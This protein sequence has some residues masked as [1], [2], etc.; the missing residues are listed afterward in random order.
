MLNG[1][2]MQFN[3][4]E[5]VVKNPE[6]ESIATAARKDNLY[7][8]NFTKVH[9]A[10]T[11]NLVRSPMGDDVLQFWH[12]HLDHLNAKGVHTLQ[13]MMSGMNLAPHHCCFAKRTSKVNNKGLRLGIP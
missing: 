2:Q 9:G 13:N 1:F 5:R 8:M 12:W 11:T 4:N 10:H 7:E 6:N 3:L